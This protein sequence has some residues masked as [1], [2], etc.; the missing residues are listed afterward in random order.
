MR[1]DLIQTIFTT[2]RIGAALAAGACGSQVG[3]ESP[4]VLDICSYEELA[5]ADVA[6]EDLP[7]S[8]AD[9]EAEVF[10]TFDVTLYARSWDEDDVLSWTV[11]E[12]VLQIRPIEGEEVKV[13]RRSEGSDFADRVSQTHHFGPDDSGVGVTTLEDCSDGYVVP[14]R[15]TLD[16]DDGALVTRG[17]W[18]VDLR[19]DRAGVSLPDRVWESEGF[20]TTWDLDHAVY[21]EAIDV[22]PWLIQD[23]STWYLSADRLTDTTATLFLEGWTEDE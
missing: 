20:E 5:L 7:F 3:S 21:G 9:R 6:S 16:V 10:G 18:D 11:H 19:A 15:V 23:G 14:A 2:A 4:F 1:H 17:R 22:R 8:L 12:G 13:V